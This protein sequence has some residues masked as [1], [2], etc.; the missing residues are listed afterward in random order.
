MS[1]IYRPI[2]RERLFTPAYRRLPFHRSATELRFEYQSAQTTHWHAF[3]ESIWGDDQQ[4]KDTLEVFKLP[5]TATTCQRQKIF[6]IIG[7]PRSGERPGA[8]VLRQLVGDGNVASP[9]RWSSLAGPLQLSQPSVGKSVANVAD[10]GVARSD[11]ATVVEHLL[12]ISGED[13]AIDQAITL[14]LLPTTDSV[15]DSVQ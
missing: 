14:L 12:S 4:N 2:W 13:N 1:S 11:Q 10:A 8:R 9:T 3:L 6:L 7:P 5:V 15:S